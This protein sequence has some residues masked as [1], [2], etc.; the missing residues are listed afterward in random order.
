MDKHDFMKIILEIL[1]QCKSNEEIE[2]RAKEMINIVNN[3]ENISKA[4][5]EAGIL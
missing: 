4:Y 5:L 2:L 1:E 3:A